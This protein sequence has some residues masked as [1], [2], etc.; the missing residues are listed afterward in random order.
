[1]DQYQK[2]FVIVLKAITQFDPEGIAPGEVFGG[3]PVDEYDIEAKP[4]TAFLN[5]NLNQVM[6][7]PS[8]LSK[9]ID[10]VWRKEFAGRK[11]HCAN[12]I[13]EEIVHKI[14]KDKLVA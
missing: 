6:S 13:A 9:E 8:V 10:R 5:E 4:I 3:V 1:M 2:I 12:E 14:S 7:D 11:C